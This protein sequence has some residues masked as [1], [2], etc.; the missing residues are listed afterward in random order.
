[1]SRSQRKKTT[2]KPDR[3]W[4]QKAFSQNK[5]A[6][7]RQLGIPEDE[8]IPEG[9]LASKYHAKGKLGRRV[10]AAVNAMNARKPGAVKVRKKR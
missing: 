6:L 9:L 7:H 3:R 4:M 1:M 8:P 2:R 10:R 5:G